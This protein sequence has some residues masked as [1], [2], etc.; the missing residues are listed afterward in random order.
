M[1]A[2]SYLRSSNSI[3][4]RTLDTNYL[5]NVL[6]T[7]YSR[8]KVKELHPAKANNNKPKEINIKHHQKI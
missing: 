8:N 7:L 4:E 2:F 3:E 5:L 1:A 6:N